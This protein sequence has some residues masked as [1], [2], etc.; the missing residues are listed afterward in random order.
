M[1]VTKACKRI[2]VL[3]TCNSGA[4][5]AKSG[6][7]RRDPFAFAGAIR[8][9]SRSEGGFTIADSSAS[10]ETAEIEQ[11]GHGVLT[12]SLPQGMQAVTSEVDATADGNN[13]GVA[14]ISEWFGCSADLVPRPKKQ[15]LV[16]EQDVHQQSEGV[17]F[18]VLPLPR[19]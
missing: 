16:V 9:L 11:L 13:D 6:T 7:K 18:P 14:N 3:D 15:Y 5:L 10:D 4:A 19:E 12:Y 8:R 17:V 2:L 1:I